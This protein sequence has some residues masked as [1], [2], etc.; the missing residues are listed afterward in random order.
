[1]LIRSSL[2]WCTHDQFLLFD[3]QQSTR[4]YCMREYSPVKAIGYST[5][6]SVA[7]PMSYAC[8]LSSYSMH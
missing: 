7:G 5:F 1:M 8:A 4:G 6:S 3:I 2:L